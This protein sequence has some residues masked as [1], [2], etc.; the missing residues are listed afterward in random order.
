ML[1]FFLCPAEHT[2]AP[3]AGEAGTHYQNADKYL[4]LL[5]SIL[6]GAHSSSTGFSPSPS[7][8]SIHSAAF[9]AAAS[10]ARE[11]R[12]CSLS[13]QF[14]VVSFRRSYALEPQAWAQVHRWPEL[15]S[16][17]QSALATVAH[18]VN[19]CIARFLRKC[20]RSTKLVQ[21]ESCVGCCCSIRATIGALVEDI[22]GLPDFTSAH[23]FTLLIAHRSAAVTAARHISRHMVNMCSVRVAKELDDSTELYS[24]ERRLIPCTTVVLDGFQ[25]RLE[26]SDFEARAEKMCL[27]RVRKCPPFEQLH[28]RAAAHRG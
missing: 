8:L 17:S 26:T 10:I 20:A 14:H 12:A 2:H 24:V 21:Q 4:S 1:A 28:C 16:F 23:I 7:C 25:R 9:G 18:L 13:S 27:A 22:V 5:L 15:C 3:T 11:T 19:P 6:Y